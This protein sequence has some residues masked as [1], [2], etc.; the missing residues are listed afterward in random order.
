M[1][2]DLSAHLLLGRGDFS[3]DVELTVA[4]GETLALLGPNG[5]GKSTALEALVGWQQLDAGSIALAGRLLDEPDSGVFVASEE[6]NI[7]VAFQ[8]NLLFP[9]MSAL[10]NVAFGVMSRGKS[11]SHARKAVGELV[12]SLG[13]SDVATQRPSQLS[14]GQAQRVALGRALAINPDLLLLDEPMAALDVTTR[15]S[16]RRLLRERLRDLRA[17]TILVTHDPADANVLAD[18]IVVLEDG[19]V[20][21]VGTPDEI[22]RRPRSAYAADLVGI[23]LITGAVRDGRITIDEGTGEQTLSTSDRSTE[24]RVVATIHPRAVALHREQPDGSPRN[25]WMATVGTVEPLGETTR[26]ELATP[27]ALTAD[28]TPGAAIDLELAP[29]RTIWVA[30][31]AT[32]I[33]VSKI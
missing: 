15:A 17:P 3:L 25:A 28:I 24:G 27:I 33:S 8:D 21:Q 16:T 12:E 13:L 18:R 30:V 7:G 11:R 26:V 14:G 19:L 5:A 6:R 1:T 22:R 29:G 23:N 10:D 2:S 32:E 9:H 4:A 31:K 20:T